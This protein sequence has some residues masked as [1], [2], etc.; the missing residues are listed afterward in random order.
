MGAGRAADQEC[1]AKSAEEFISKHGLR[2][3]RKTNGY[4]MS[5][6]LYCLYL[7]DCMEQ[8]EAIEDGILFDECE[9][10]ILLKNMEEAKATMEYY[11]R[12]LHMDYSSFDAAETIALEGCRLENGKIIG[13]VQ[14]AEQIARMWI[15]NYT[16]GEGNAFMF[17]VGIY[18][19]FLLGQD[20]QFMQ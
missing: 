16:K 17:E 6:G 20:V 5:L 1:E 12:L 7:V 3:N 8:A 15:L 19:L 2:V 18:I 11:R 10:T 4:Q 14:A 9:V 13:D